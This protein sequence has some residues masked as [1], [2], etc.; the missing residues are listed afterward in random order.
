MYTRPR[1]ACH[2]NSAA[3]GPPGGGRLHGRHG[4][5]RAAVFQAPDV[6]GNVLRG[7]ALDSL[8]GH[9]H[10]SV[11]HAGQQ[12]HLHRL[13]RLG[14]RRGLVAA[15]A[16]P[17][18]PGGPG[19]GRLPR[20]SFLSAGGGHERLRVLREALRKTHPDVRLAG[21]HPRSFLEDGLCLLPAGADRQHHDRLGHL[22]GDCGGGRGDG[23][24]H[25]HRRAGSRHLDRRVPGADYVARYLHLPRLPLAAS[26]RRAVGGA[27]AGL[28]QSQVQPGKRLAGLRQANPSGAVALRLF[29]V[30]A[31]VR[32]RP[33]GGAAL[34]GGPGPT[35]RRDR[36]SR[37]APSC[38]CWCGRCS[39]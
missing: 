28:G 36:A 37:W 34:P 12:R 9:G 15:G 30:P 21:L 39:C 5:P 20:H 14:V 13:S 38:A 18:D 27:G 22:L 16:R 7:P 25:G 23:F 6:H 19:A 31:E 29:L 24:L 8:L 11:R 26:A 32:G 2:D 33:D 4:L 1:G 3:A 17:D 35:G 10:L